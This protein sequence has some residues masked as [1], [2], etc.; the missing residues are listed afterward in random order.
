MKVE[1]RPALAEDIA[2]IAADARAAD[3]AEMAALGTSVEQAMRDGLRLSDWAVTGLLDDVPV[4]MFGVAP[5]SVLFGEGAPWLLS[6][7][8][9]LRGQ[10]AFLKA[11]RP[12]VDAMRASYPRLI[13]IIDQDNTIAMRWLRWLG[14]GFD[15][16]RIPFRGRVFRVFRLGDW[17]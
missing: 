15:D 3:V 14:F 12:V 8:G 2:A 16:T 17:S 9:L 5:V 13:N 11:C 10:K 1:L 7:T 6:A 4:C